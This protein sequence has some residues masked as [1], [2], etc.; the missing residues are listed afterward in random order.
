MELLAY[1]CSDKVVDASQAEPDGQEHSVKEKEDKELV[2]GVTNT[3]V[4]PGGERG[5][6]M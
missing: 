1:P 3:V 5:E 4:H 6:S 2:V